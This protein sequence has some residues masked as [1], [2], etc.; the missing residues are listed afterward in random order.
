MREQSNIRPDLER[1]L[2]ELRESQGT[3]GV[4]KAG[5]REGRLKFGMS[6]MARDQAGN[7]DVSLSGGT[8]EGQ[9]HP[10]T[11]LMSYSSG[12][13][14]WMDDTRSPD[15]S[16]V[17]TLCNLL[18]PQPAPDATPTEEGSPELTEQTLRTDHDSHFYP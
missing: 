8:V 1:G 16:N 15:T 18:C 9:R 6:S 14:V 13:A 2:G 10:G 7:T 17:L 4:L 5:R 3:L 11:Q 12:M